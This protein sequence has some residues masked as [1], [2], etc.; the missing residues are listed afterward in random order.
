MQAVFGPAVGLLRPM[1]SS[2]F[3]ELVF[4]AGGK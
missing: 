3:G 2:S 1:L 4:I